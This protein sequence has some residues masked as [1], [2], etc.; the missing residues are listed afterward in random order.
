[1]PYVGLLLFLPVTELSN[2]IVVRCVNALRRA[3][4]ISTVSLMQNCICQRMCQCPTSG[5]SYF[6]TT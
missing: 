2:S 4:P 1:M 5:F 6:Y 3:S